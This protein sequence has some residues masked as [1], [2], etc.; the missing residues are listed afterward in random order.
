MKANSL[1]RSS[2]GFSRLAVSVTALSIVGSASAV[3]FDVGDPDFKVRWD[4]SVRYNLGFRAQGKEKALSL[5]NNQQ[6]SDNKFDRGDVVTNRFDLLS[7]LDVVYKEEYGARVSASAWYDQAYDDDKAEGLSQ[8]T[9]AGYPNV[10]SGNKYTGKVD[11]YYNGPS[12]EILDAFV[13]GRFDIGDAPV[14]VKLGRHNL[15][16]G[17]SLFSFI[18][19]VS[20][21]QGPV[22]IRKATATP[23][24]EAK[25][26]YLPLNQ[27]SFHTQMTDTLS[28]AG[29]YQFEWDPSRL[30]EGG[31]Y[32][33]TADFAFGGNTTIPA[34]PFF[35]IPYRG[36]VDTPKNSGSWGTNL[37]WQSEALQGSLGFYYREFSDTLPNILS[38]FDGAGT[39]TSF[40]NRYAENVRLYGISISRQIGGVAVAG[41]LSRRENTALSSV[42]GSPDFARG[43]TWHGLVNAIA[44]FGKTPLWDSATLMGEMTYSRLDK[45]TKNAEFYNE[46]G[47]PLCASQNGGRGDAKDGCSTKDALGIQ[48]AFTPTWY[49]P[50]NGIDLTLP[51]TY[52]R[53]I[54][55][56]SPVTNGGNEGAGAFSIGI[57]ADYLAL[58]KATLAYN[59]FFG[60]LTTRFNPVVNDNTVATSSGGSPLLRDRGWVSLTLKASF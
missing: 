1:K 10:Y 14:R 59:G 33:G 58:Y 24:I 54:F 3:S 38:T 43:D 21:A 56:T 32:F 30:P 19:G 15:Y 5:S 46:K 11:R 45:V 47:N 34:A 42:G 50:I 44:Y 52:G 55:G 51:M 37:K 17:E 53:G 25:E 28:L 6:V 2:A 8:Y 29:Y 48:L 18:H 31:T 39:P 26:L 60:P 40:Y 20:Y 41:E 36:D 23:G 27:L 4:N 57:G 13:F 35:G 7:E 12:G 16:W 49:Q 22:D 9:A